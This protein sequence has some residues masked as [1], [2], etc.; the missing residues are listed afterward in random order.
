MFETDKY[1]SGLIGEYERLFAPLKDKSIKY[2]EVGIHK[3][4]SLLWAKDYFDNP[5]AN[6][7]GI[8]KELP[9]GECK[10]IL[11]N[12]VSIL[13]LEA[14]QASFENLTR[15]TLLMLRGTLR[16]PEEGLDIIIDDGCHFARET[17]TTFK[18]L[19][20]LLKS[21][22]IYIIEDWAAPY[23]F[24][25]EPRYKG[26]PDLV[27]SLAKREDVAG[28]KIVHNIPGCSGSYAAYWKK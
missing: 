25:N 17:E 7:F 20:P 15:T 5:K 21:G 19:W 14:D 3:G 22:G 8:D 28:V 27:K 10:D 6:I 12:Q 4:G 9:T 2:L 13:M 26:M 16:N 18:A 24:P 23:A 11:N 1:A